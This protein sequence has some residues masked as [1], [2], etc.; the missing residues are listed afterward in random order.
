MDVWG[1][2]NYKNAQAEVTINGIARTIAFGNTGDDTNGIA[3]TDTHPT[4]DGDTTCV[5]GSGYGIWQLCL[6]D[7]A[8]LLHTDGTANTV[9]VS[10]TDPNAT[11]FDGRVCDISLVSIYQDPSID[12]TL[13]FYLAEADGSLRKSPGTVGAPMTRSLTISGIDTTDVIAATYTAGYTHGSTGQNDQVYFNG[14]DLDDAGTDVALGTS[15]DY[16]SS[17]NP[18]DISLFL[19]ETSTIRYSVDESEIGATA[20]TSVRANVGLLTVTHTATVPE[21]STISLLI[22]GTVMLLGMRWSRKR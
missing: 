21:P 7:V 22:L 8:D 18:F 12:Q 20:E 10:I 19:M 3:T 4:Y 13:D 9:N 11:A 1:G 16:G 6:S 14:E 2:S 17:N 5:Y 15:S